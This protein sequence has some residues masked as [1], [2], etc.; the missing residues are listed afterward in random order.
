MQAI[1]NLN[2]EAETALITIKTLGAIN[3]KKLS[4]KESQINEGLKW[5]NQL[6][7][8]LDSESLENII[9]IKKSM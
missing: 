6:L 5:L 7:T 2:Q 1:I 3:G 8:S 4:N 9:N